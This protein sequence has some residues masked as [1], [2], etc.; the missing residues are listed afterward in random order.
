M[1]TS[2]YGAVGVVNGYAYVIAGDTGADVA[3]TAVYYGKLNSDGSTGAWSTNSTSIPA[4]RGYITGGLYNGYF[5]VL[6]GKDNVPNVKNSVYYASTSRIQVGGSL[7]LVGLG[8]SSLAD[9]GSTG[10]SLTAAD[11]VFVGNLQVQG[12]ANFVQGVGVGG[13]FS[14]QGAVGINSNAD[15]NSGFLLADKQ[16]SVIINA[17]AI[18][19]GNLLNDGNFEGSA[20]THHGL[21]TTPLP[22]H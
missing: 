11:G 12:S 2:I 18:A 5:Y 4:V 17:S 7:D 13:S 3:Q 21:V 15:S 1:P 14:V 6:G 10:G 20:V 9:A 22:M 16:G 19:A 8:G